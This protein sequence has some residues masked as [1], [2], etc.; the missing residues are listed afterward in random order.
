MAMSGN[1]T[2]NVGSYGKI[3]V[4]INVTSQSVANNT[5]RVR[6]RGQMALR[7]GSRAFNN[8]G[9]SMRIYGTN[10]ITS[11]SSTTPFDVGTSWKTVRDETYTVSHAADGRRSISA[12]FALGNT[13]TSSFGSGG[14]VTKSLTID[15]IPRPPSKPGKPTV[16]GAT[17]SS[18]KASVSAPASN[19]ASITQYQ[20][21]VGNSNFTSSGRSITITGRN[22]NSQHRVRVRARNSAGW[23]SWSAW[24]NYI[25]TKPN[26][27]AAPSN[28]RPQ[29]SGGFPRVLWN[30]NAT[31]AAPYSSIT[32]QWG[33][34]DGTKGWQDYSSSTTVAGTAT[35]HQYSSQTPNRAYRYR[36][37]ANNAAGSSAWAYMPAETYLWT[38]P[39]APSNATAKVTSSGDSID[40]AW[41]NN[42]YQ[43]SGDTATT[44]QI[45]RLSGST[46][47]T[48]QSG[49]SR[50]T[51]G[52]RDN[53]PLPG[54]NRYR[55]RVRHAA[56][57]FDNE[58][59]KYSAWVETNTVST[60]APPL[61][62]TN[63]SPDGEVVDFF[64]SETH[65]TWQHNDSG[66]G[67]AQT[68]YQAQYRV[69]GVLPS[70]QTL[71]NGTTGHP[72]VPPGVLSNGAVYEWRVRTKGI[73][74]EFGPW[75]SPAFVT[76][77]TRPT[78]TLRDGEPGESIGELPF[79]VAWDYQQDEDYSQDRYEVRVTQYDADSEGEPTGDAR[80]VH[81]AEGSGEVDEVEFDSLPSGDYVFF[82]E[83]RARSSQG[84]WS[85]WAL[86]QSTVDLLPPAFTNLELGFDK[87]S[88]MVS[89]DLSA[90]EPVT[91][92]T[93]PP[94]R[95]DLQRRARRAP[96]DYSDMPDPS[97]RYSWEG[98]PNNSPSVRVDGDGTVINVFPNPSF[99][100]EGDTVTIWNNFSANPRSLEGPMTPNDSPNVS[101]RRVYG[102][103][104]EGFGWKTRVVCENSN[105]VPA[106]GIRDSGLPPPPPNEQGGIVLATYS[107]EVWARI[108]SETMQYVTKFTATYGQRSQTVAGPFPADEWFKLETQINLRS[109][110][111]KADLVLEFDTPGAQSDDFIEFTNLW[112]TD[113]VI[114]EGMFFDSTYENT[115]PDMWMTELPD[116]GV[117]LVGYAALSAT[118][119]GLVALKSSQWAKEGSE[120]LR[121]FNNSGSAGY[122]LVSGGA[123]GNASVVRYL[124]SPLTDSP[125]GPFSGGIVAGLYDGGTDL[126]DVIPP[127]E[128]GESVMRVS[129][130][131]EEDWLYIMLNGSTTLGESVW[132]DLLTITEE[133]YDGLP[134]SGDSPDATEWLEENTSD[135]DWDE[136]WVTIAQNIPF[137]GSVSITDRIPFLNSV[138]EYRAI[139]VAESSGSAIFGGNLITLDAN[140]AARAYV[141][142]GQTF[143]KSLFFENEPDVGY[144]TERVMETV[145][146][147]GRRKPLLLQGIQEERIADV[148]GMLLCDYPIGGDYLP[149]DWEAMVTEAGVV[150][151]RD[152]TGRRLFGTIGRFNYEPLNGHSLTHFNFNFSLIEVDYVEQVL[153]VEE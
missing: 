136:G 145:P 85:E 113:V 97:I 99:H 130:T 35:A 94:A 33:M 93:S 47:S 17:S 58:G 14:T 62:P 102:N 20:W 19:G 12:S 60:I 29:W 107:I 100:S 103:L 8:N 149:S 96:W 147:L 105:L 36:V 70:W 101:G 122:I 146:L 104:P 39:A 82:T 68:A 1:A 24:S 45:Q 64:N 23:S 59:D 81:R 43:V 119:L 51:S 95:F 92:V 131:S 120:S 28:V 57:Q 40:V 74:P 115:D 142:W 98:E 77:G 80:V 37:R 126:P 128:A 110:L 46:W 38:A 139:V 52:W 114:P 31:T 127:N 89:V 78:V 22:P 132:F 123:P 117:A 16:S 53:S 140:N 135:S 141:S 65:F 124:D 44:L 151:Y 90:E 153:I 125:A 118:V 6:V 138:N 18:F 69:A 76:G 21:Q 30:R 63:L 61:A 73:D 84:Q 91:G 41:T 112:V 129:N 121:L 152:P 87:H 5:S 86:R 2:K 13:G 49:L 72:I 67:S 150:C 71:A 137:E 79:T 25:S 116:G 55:I 106:M 133:P 48:I 4:L 34:Y 42:H 56:G 15:R 50:T 54:D 134:F 32:V 27:P 11:R 3:R 10:G 75:S 143:E 108:P 7:Q 9:V 83:V 88:G 109:D 66:D 148:A 26:R 144:S 111:S